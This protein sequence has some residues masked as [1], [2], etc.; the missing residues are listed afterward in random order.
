MVKMWQWRYETEF[1]S[2]FDDFFTR[3]GCGLKWVSGIHKGLEQKFEVKG[4]WP[5]IRSFN[6]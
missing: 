4:F 1:K 3:K 2:V 5:W 6:F